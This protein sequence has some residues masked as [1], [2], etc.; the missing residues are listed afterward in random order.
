M[1]SLVVDHGPAQESALACGGA[2]TDPADGGQRPAGDGATTPRGVRRGTNLAER[3]YERA[4]FG[5]VPVL[6]SPDFAAQI[7]AM[8]REHP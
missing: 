5:D 1:S 4:R 7:R 2:G 6:V 8:R 3:G